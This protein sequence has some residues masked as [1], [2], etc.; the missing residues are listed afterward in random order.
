MRSHDSAEP[1]SA[2]ASLIASSALIAACPFTTRDNATRETLRRSANSVTVIP[3]SARSTVSFR[4]APGCGG[5][6]MRLIKKI[7]SVVVLVINQDRVSAFKRES[8]TPISI[9]RHSP[10]AG[11]IILER[12]PVPAR[13]I[14]IRGADGPIKSEQLQAQFLR[15]VRLNASLRSRAEEPPQSV[16][17]PTLDHAG[18]CIA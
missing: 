9:H 2:A 5:L 1:P 14:H 12:V 7:S 3:P 13:Q 16:V 18:Q 4:T 6:C 17:A 15:M 10:M 8:H 11:Q